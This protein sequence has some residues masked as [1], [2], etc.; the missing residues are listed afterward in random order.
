VRSGGRTTVVDVGRT[1]PQG[2]TGPIGPVGP[3][4]PS[5]SSYTHT[6]ASSS[7]TWTIPHNLGFRPTITVLTDGG[8]E[9][10]TDVIHLSANTAQV[11]LVAPM[12]GTARCT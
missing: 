11:S 4:G 1:G 3:A 10:V 12:T 2:A 9:V 7:A 5:A 6:Q 8:I